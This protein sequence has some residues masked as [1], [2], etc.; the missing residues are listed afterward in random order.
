MKSKNITLLIVLFLIFDVGYIFSQNPKYKNSIKYKSTM[1]YRYSNRDLSKKDTLYLPI[2]KPCMLSILVMCYVRDY[3][4]INN[5]CYLQT[6]HRLTNEYYMLNDDLEDIENC[7]WQPNY[8][9]IMPQ[10]TIIYVDSFKHPAHDVILTKVDEKIRMQY[11]K[12][13][14]EMGNLIVHYM[15]LIEMYLRKKITDEITLVCDTTTN[16]L[17][18]HIDILILPSRDDN[19]LSICKPSPKNNFHEKKHFMSGKR[20]HFKNLPHM[21]N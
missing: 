3:Q 1:D 4:K 18:E 11:W 14:T 5:N 10:T 17:F 9:R 16:T 19:C 8:L 13:Q 7:C 15:P 20:R 6:I 12:A 21:S 2:D